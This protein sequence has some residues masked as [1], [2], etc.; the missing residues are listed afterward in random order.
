MV[1]YTSVMVGRTFLAPPPCDYGLHQ[2][3]AVWVAAGDFILLLLLLGI[4][5]GVHDCSC[6]SSLDILYVRAL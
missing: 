6:C 1:L 4:G 5:W 2:L 3:A